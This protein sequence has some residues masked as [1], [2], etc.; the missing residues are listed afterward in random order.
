MR[1]GDDLYIMPE[2]FYVEQTFYRNAN[3]RKLLFSQWYAHA[4]YNVE[5]YFIEKSSSEQTFHGV[6]RFLDVQLM[7]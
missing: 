4:N 3:A 7:E 2:I 1:G 6:I 5:L